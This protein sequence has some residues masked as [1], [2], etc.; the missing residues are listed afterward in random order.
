[1][2]TTRAQLDVWH[3]FVIPALYKSEVGKL[4]TS[5]EPDLKK[6]KEKRA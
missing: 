3:T 5:G 1:M 4:V 2:K 6:K